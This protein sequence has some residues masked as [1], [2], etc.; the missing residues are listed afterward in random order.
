MK[1]N[2]TTS[3]RSGKSKPEDLASPIYVS[4]RLPSLVRNLYADFDRRHFSATKENTQPTQDGS[5]DVLIKSRNGKFKYDI[6]FCSLRDNIRPITA[7]EARIG[8]TVIERVFSHFAIKTLD[9]ILHMA[10]HDDQVALEC[11]EVPVRLSEGLDR[12]RSVFQR[13]FLRR[14][15]VHE[16]VMG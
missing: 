2:S 3:E 4:R 12:A 6:Q 8:T 7:T 14:A 10:R 11:G 13:S 9:C 1:N 16:Y 15:S 5:F